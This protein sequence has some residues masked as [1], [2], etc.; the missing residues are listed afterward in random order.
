MKTQ[1]KKYICIAKDK[2]LNYYDYWPILGQSTKK[3]TVE[4][5]IF[6]QDSLWKN[7]YIFYFIKRSYDSLFGLE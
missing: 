1:K 4:G 7:T 6:N 5:A 3:L 2:V